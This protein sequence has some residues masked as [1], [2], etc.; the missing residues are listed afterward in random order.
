MKGL[1]EI[2]NVRRHT[3]IAKKLWGKKLVITYFLTRGRRTFVRITL[4]MPV[5]GLLVTSLGN[6]IYGTVKT[7]VK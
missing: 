4:Q 7:N 6:A 5:D 1:Q 2:E 3:R